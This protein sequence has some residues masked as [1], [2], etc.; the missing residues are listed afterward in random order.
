MAFAAWTSGKILEEKHPFCK[1]SRVPWQI[2]TQRFEGFSNFLLFNDIQCFCDTRIQI[3]H[4]G[5]RVATHGGYSHFQSGH[6]GP[7][8]CGKSTL[9]KAINNEQVRQCSALGPHWLSSH[10]QFAY[11]VDGF[12]PKSELVTAFVEHGVGETEPEC[13]SGKPGYQNSV[14]VMW[15]WVGKIYF[16]WMIS[17]SGLN[18]PK[19]LKVFDWIMLSWYLCVSL[20]S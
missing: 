20:P 11:K 1:T 10:W 2:E 18:L 15:F 16:K 12:P 8:D 9:L 14:E 6:W 3:L 4:S 19:V 7:N 5:H 13:E 17:W